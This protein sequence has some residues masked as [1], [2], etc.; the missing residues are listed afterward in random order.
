MAVMAARCHET[1]D[2]TEAPA[3]DCHFDPF[4]WSMVS[5]P[6]AHASR[7]EIATTAFNPVKRPPDATPC[8]ATG[9][10]T[11]VLPRSADHPADARGAA[12]NPAAAARLEAC[13]PVHAPASSKAPAARR[14]DKRDRTLPSHTSSFVEDFRCSAEPNGMCPFSRSRGS[15]SGIAHRAG[16][17][18][19]VK[20]VEVGRHLDRR[21]ER[22]GNRPRPLHSSSG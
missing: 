16:P 19:H 1:P 10:V 5:F 22:P 8:S 9:A 7:E 15:F 6:T 17:S 2:G 11:A 4:Q 14:R 20:P 12:L 13:R 18:P 3:T 21:A